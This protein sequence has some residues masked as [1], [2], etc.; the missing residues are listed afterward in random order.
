[1]H[2]LSARPRCSL[3]HTLLGWLVPMFLLVGATSAV[4][5]YWTFGRMVSTFMDD[6]ME[7]LALSVAG[8]EQSAVFP[9][10]TPERIHKWGIYVIQVYDGQGRL[11]ASSYPQLDAGLSDAPG[12][13]DLRPMARPGGLCDAL[14]P[15]AGGAGVQSGDFRRH[16]A[17]ARA[18]AALRRC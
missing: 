14:A 11:Q 9:P 4:F 8:Q 18:G 5:S 7:Q 16:L 15:A 13:R 12:F 3:R 6:Q 10:M 2:I 1:M 17:A